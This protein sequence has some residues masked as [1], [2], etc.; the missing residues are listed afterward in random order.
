MK[1]T[2]VVKK[3][4]SY[5]GES[6][7]DDLVAVKRNS[8]VTHVLIK[9][10]N[11]MGISREDISLDDYRLPFST[12]VVNILKHEGYKTVGS[13]FKD[14]SRLPNIKGVGSSSL[15][16]IHSGLEVLGFDIN[17]AMSKQGVSV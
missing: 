14:L 1:I 2:E 7:Y 10:V 3:E 16:D 9:H 11:K 8:L 5:S 12:R 17:M 15:A 4:D 13:V 6:S